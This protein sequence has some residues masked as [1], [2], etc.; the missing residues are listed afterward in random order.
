[1]GNKKLETRIKNLENQLSK[2]ICRNCDGRGKT[3]IS[4]IKHY[5]NTSECKPCVECKGSGVSQIILNGASKQIIYVL[6]RGQD[7]GIRPRD[8]V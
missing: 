8:C 5:D 4:G 1:M 7:Q 6:E 2:L 3:A